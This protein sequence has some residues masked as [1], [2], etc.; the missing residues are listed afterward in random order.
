MNLVG[1][2]FVVLILV[3]SVL[4]MAFAMAVYATHQNWRDVVVNE[5][6]TPDKPLGLAPQL[7]NLQGPQQGPHATRMRS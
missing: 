3:M 1:K 7:K 6:A 2:I 5:Q 4:F